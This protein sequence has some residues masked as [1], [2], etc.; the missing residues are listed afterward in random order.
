MPDLGRFA[1]EKAV[2]R[3]L[4]LGLDPEVEFEYS[5]K[6]AGTVLAT[7]PRPGVEVQE[8][9]TVTLLVA[10]PPP[11]VPLVIGAK[12]S[13]ARATLKEA[14][15]RVD[16]RTKATSEADPGTVVDQ[17]PGLAGRL[18]PGGTVTII[19][20]KAEPPP[21]D[22]NYSGACVP[23]VSYD[24]DCADINGPVYVGGSDPHRFD[25]DGDGVGCET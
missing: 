19:V 18:M 23:I 15:Y 14:G 11:V 17:K 3:L 22:P 9:G 13:Q 2:A 7:T 4:E 20:A 16:V 24:L 12:E 25:G 10:K 8:G 6:Q 1:R 21:C 5:M